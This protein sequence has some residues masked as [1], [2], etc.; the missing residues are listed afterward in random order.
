M[1]EATSVAEG[2]T[3]RYMYELSFL[4][5]KISVDIVRA[6]TVSLDVVEEHIKELE[7]W[8]DTVPESM[9]L[10]RPDERLLDENPAWMTSTVERTK[11]AKV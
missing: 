3:Q 4:L 7:K 5:R 2:T 8:S 6:D 11:S 9:D 10:F 1:W